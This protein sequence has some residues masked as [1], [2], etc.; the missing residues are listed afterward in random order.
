MTKA[1]IAAKKHANYIK[2]KAA[3]PEEF[4]RR[5][6]ANMERNRQAHPEKYRANYI[7]RAFGISLKE[8]DARKAD[9]LIVHGATCWVCGRT[10]KMQGQ[11]KR[12]EKGRRIVVDHDHETGQLRGLLCDL[13]NTSL[14]KLDD[15]PASVFAL[16][17]YICKYKGK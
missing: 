4:A 12:N 17:Q 1:E 11:F 3:N 13:C 14:G 16:Y 9:L 8:F 5:V 6:R 7:R 15:N 10:G 2:R